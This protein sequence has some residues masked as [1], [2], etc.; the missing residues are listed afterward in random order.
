MSLCYLCMLWFRHIKSSNVPLSKYVWLLPLFRKMS[1]EKF[2]EAINLKV[3]SGQNKGA[4]LQKN[5]LKCH[6]QLREIG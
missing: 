6:M 5:Q 4:G 2:C 1:D 3:Y